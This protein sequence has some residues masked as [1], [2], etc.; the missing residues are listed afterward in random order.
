MII[1]TNENKTETIPFKYP[2]KDKVH[3]LFSDE[4]TCFLIAGI[5]FFKIANGSVSSAGF[6]IRNER[7][8]LVSIDRSAQTLTYELGKQK[9]LLVYRILGS[10]MAAS[11][12]KSS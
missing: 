10:K 8:E 6:A 9:M 2:N 3:Y 1:D 12:C 7:V 5:R 11:I 4:D